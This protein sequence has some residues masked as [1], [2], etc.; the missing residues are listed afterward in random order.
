M[1][2][3]KS[4]RFVFLP[5]ILAFGILWLSFA[6]LALWPLA[7]IAYCPLIWLILSPNDNVSCESNSSSAFPRNGY[8]KIYAASV[9]YWLS[10]FYF[11]PIPH[12]ALW[13]GWIAVSVY[14]AIYTPIFV[15]ASRSL[16]HQ[17]KVPAWLAIPS[18]FTGLEWFRCH[19]ASGMTMV[20]LSHSQFRAPMLIQV[21]DLSGAYTLTWIMIGF[22]TGLTLAVHRWRMQANMASDSKNDSSVSYRAIGLPLLL[23]LGLMMAT[24]GYGWFRLNQVDRLLS[25]ESSLPSFRAAIIQTNFD[26]VLAPLTKDEIDDRI[27]KTIALTRQCLDAE[28]ALVVW[29]EGGLYPMHDYLPVGDQSSLD[30]AAMISKRN[31]FDYW[32]EAMTQDATLHRVPLLAGSLTIDQKEQGAYNSALLIDAEGRVI[33]RYYKRHLVM[34][35][36]YVPLADQ[37]PLIAALSPMPN[38]SVGQSYRR[39]SIGDF[40]FAPSI[41]FESTVPHLVRDQINTLESE[42]GSSRIDAMINLTNDGWFFGTSCLDM[43]LACNVFRAVEMR[44]PHLVCANTGLSAN[45]DPAGRMI[46]TGPRRDSAVLICDVRSIDSTSLYRQMGEWFPRVFGYSA[47]TVWLW[48]VIRWFRQRNNKSV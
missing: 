21:A 14:M 36:E 16:I 46:Q 48:T 28:P 8:R 31:F 45:I 26:V 24:L 4:A 35:G 13:A 42:N 5:A 23:S 41:C 15:V 29:A 47:I 7:W 10:T 1:A 40:Q 18:I 37:V 9:L 25:K 17:F 3:S 43:H 32:T 19:F 34:F 6:P 20:C 44:K 22:G 2:E 30:E 27:E 38:L 33:D 39:M 12:P 11:I